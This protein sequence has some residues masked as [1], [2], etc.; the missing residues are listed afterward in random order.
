M[1]ETLQAINRQ[2]Y[3]VTFQFSFF[4]RKLRVSVF[5][6][7][8]SSDLQISESS[9][10]LFPIFRF[11]DTDFRIIGFRIF[12]LTCNLS[13]RFSLS[14]RYSASNN[15]LMCSPRSHQPIYVCMTFPCCVKAKFVFIFTFSMF[16]VL[17][18]PPCP[19]PPPLYEIRTEA[20]RKKSSY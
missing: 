4:W 3:F 17:P 6:I 5:R 2:L 9:D 10:F 12:E 7:F 1:Y 15:M 20:I 18:C 8:R 11:S 16:V 13:S 14:H 19:P